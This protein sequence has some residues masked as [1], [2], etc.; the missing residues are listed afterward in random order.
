MSW[1][2]FRRYVSASEQHAQTQKK[3]KAFQATGRTIEPLGELTHRLKIATSF[4]GRSWCQHLESF[5]DY[6]NRLPR[7]RTYVRNGSVLHLGIQQ[8][9]VEALVQGSELYELAIHI[10]PLPAKKWQAIQTRCRGK[11]GSLIELLQGRISDEIMT[12]VTDQSGGLFPNPKEIR[13]KCSCPDWAVMCKHV[14][15]V[16]Y[17]VGAR[18]DTAPELLFTL[19]GVDHNALIALDDASALAAPRRSTRR[20]TLDPTAI[21]S[22]FAIDLDTTPPAEP[23]PVSPPP[24]ASAEPAPA[25]PPKPKS[26]PKK[27]SRSPA[28]SRAATP[29]PTVFRADALTLRALRAA[30]GQSRSTFARTL[31]VSTAL[32]TRWEQAKSP[33]TIPAKVQRKLDRLWSAVTNGEP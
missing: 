26:P 19:R 25:P 20:R 5:S 2:S 27:K 16:L 13:L 6:E 22:V 3:L 21:G 18:L 17:G 9:V 1:Y 33:P 15:A 31:G 14:A 30:Q 32:L 11:I 10:D 24:S 8:G 4:W 29:Q 7:G 12:V 28:P 23:L